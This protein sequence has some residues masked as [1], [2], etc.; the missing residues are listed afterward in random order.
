[1]ACTDV[2]VALDVEVDDFQ[3]LPALLVDVTDYVPECFVVEDYPSIV[4]DTKSQP[5][6]ISSGKGVGRTE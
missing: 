5:V 2:L 1:M 3:Q 4:R 6:I